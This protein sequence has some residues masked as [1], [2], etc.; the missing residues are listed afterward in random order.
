MF[1][2]VWYS[3]VKT[4]YFVNLIQIKVMMNKKP[5]NYGATNTTEI[6]FAGGSSTEF[7][8]F[9]DSVVTNIYTINAS[10]KTLDVAL[11]SLGTSRDN[12]GL[13]DKMFVLFWT[14]FYSFFFT[15][16]YF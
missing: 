12:K 6:Q 8:S 4:N 15:I 2:Y 9:C 1:I 10:W 11:K 3:V 14:V 13:R 7:N 16:N 5:T